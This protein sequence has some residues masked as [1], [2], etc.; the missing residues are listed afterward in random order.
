MKVWVGLCFA[1]ALALT[2]C[3]QKGPL[4]LPQQPEQAQAEPI[5][6]SSQA[7]TNHASEDSQ[8]K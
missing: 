4:Y 8:A 7:Q 3:G 6:E 2:G 5:I 1:A